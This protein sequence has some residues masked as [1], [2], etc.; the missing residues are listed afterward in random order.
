[1]TGYHQQRSHTFT[2]HSSIP[3][4]GLCLPHWLHEQCSRTGLHLGLCLP[5]HVSYFPSLL[6]LSETHLGVGVVLGVSLAGSIGSMLGVYYT[7]PEKTFQKHAF[8]LVSNYPP[9]A[10]YFLTSY[11][12]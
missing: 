1:M 5:T 10:G 2:R 7:P 4:V 9:R 3:V 6:S 12:L 11:P 8:W